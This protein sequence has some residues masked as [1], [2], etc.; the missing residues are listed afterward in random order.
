MK[1]IAFIF[2]LLVYSLAHT[3]EVIDLGDTPWKFIREEILIPEVAEG[4]S[5][6]NDLLFTDTLSTRKLNLPLELK[7][8]SPVK[9]NIRK[10]KIRFRSDE[11]ATL[12]YTLRF[13]DMDKNGRKKLV[14][15]KDFIQ[16][17]VTNRKVGAVSDIHQTVGSLEYTGETYLEENLN[18]N[19]Q[20][21]EMVIVSQRDKEGQDILS[22]P[23][24]FRIYESVNEKSPAEPHYND[25]A[26][27]QVG[28]P[29][30]YNDLNTFLNI[31]NS[32][33]CAWRGD[34]WYRKHL[35]V[36]KKDEGKRF[37]IEFQ[38]VDVGAAVYVN[39]IFQSG[40]SQI[41]QPE[42]VTHVGG[43]LPFALDIT[44]AVKA[45]QENII[46]VRVGNAPNSFFVWP[47]F[48]VHACFGMG[49]GGI[50]GKAYLHIVNPVHIPLN[51]DSKEGEWGTYVATKEANDEKAVVRVIT[52][53]RNGDTRERKVRLITRILDKSD[54]TVALKEDM[55]VIGA[56]S[57]YVADNQFEVK[58]P[59]LWYPNNS[60][61]GKPYLYRVV[62]EVYDG[63][64]E[65]DVFTT[66]L[67]IRTITWDDDYCYIN[68]KKHILNGFGHRNLY[69]ALGAAVPV[70]LQWRDIE[71]IAQAG[72]NTL[73]V[74]HS[75]ATVEM[76]KASN[77]Y[78]ILLIQNSGDNEW[79]LKNEPANSYKREY[80]KQTIIA[81]RNAPSVIIWESNN[82]IARDGDIYWPS[83][84]LEIVNQY[85]FI[86]PRIVLNRDNYPKQHWNPEDRIV[87]GYTNG[88][89]KVK[90]S[91]TLDTEVYG[92]V[93]TGEKCNSIARFDY[94]NEKQFSEW[95]LKDYLS[96]IRDSACG[97]IDWMLTETFGESYTVYLDGKKNQK[98]LGSCA[99]DGNRIPKL[100]YNI[101]KNAFWI[102]YQTKPG[103]VLQSSVD[104]KSATEVNAWSNCPKVELFVNGQSRGV[105]VPDQMMKNCTWNISWK[106]GEYKVAGLDHAG[107]VV[108]T[109]VRHTSGDPYRIVLSLQEQMVKPDGEQFVLRANGSD[110]AIVQATIVDKN[111]NVCTLADNNIWFEVSGEGIYKGSYNFFNTEGKPLNYH[112]PG[113]REL[114]AEGGLMKVAVRSTFNPGKVVVKAYADNLLHGVVEY[115]TF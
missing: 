25:S 64:D 112:T 110:A 32:E 80:D 46:S 45:G 6:I 33:D 106:E 92:A 7:Y 67:G 23:L 42:P 55:I 35:Y 50:N 81:F 79:T 90:G 1:Y 60:P 68:G 40:T 53:V 29:H 21:V 94:V 13:Y 43:F 57:C 101:Y 75:P 26:W 8:H 69:P 44:D 49:L 34:V 24:Y 95:Y 65:I 78:G 107:N 56:N 15:Q 59:V 113:D 4:E 109:D 47:Q 58:K 3:R 98:S 17:K 39:G 20:L 48:G 72:A 100:K 31:G 73:R 66:S 91:P 96:N 87:V 30:C 22:L 19:A 62:N 84:T 52:N 97:W 9:K 38:S 104:I 16:R 93:W 61:Y 103:V 2:F 82:G 76:V 63:K 10:V 14:G 11:I 51:V 71:L 102:D 12:D 54:K 27:E 41:G 37:L 99:M 115:T 105:V 77:V 108:C 83:Y 88:Y 85:D 28:I 70:E 89:R 74:G 5:R 86:R 111:G 18:V 36:D 114:Q